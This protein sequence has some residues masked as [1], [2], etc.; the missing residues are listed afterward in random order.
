MSYDSIKNGQVVTPD[1][2]VQDANIACQRW[3]DCSHTSKG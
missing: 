2:L 3:Q 1:H